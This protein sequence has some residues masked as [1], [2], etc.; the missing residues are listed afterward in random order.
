MKRSQ[1][2][3]AVIDLLSCVIKKEVP[4]EI[5]LHSDFLT[6]QEKVECLLFDGVLSE[7]QSR[8][9]IRRLG[10]HLVSC[11]KVQ[12]A[13]LKKVIEYGFYRPVDRELTT[14][15]QD[16]VAMNAYERTSSDSISSHNLMQS[17]AAI[18]HSMASEKALREMLVYIDED[19]KPES[20]LVHVAEETNKK[21]LKF[22][23]KILKERLC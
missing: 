17:L 5:I 13:W 15:S 14:M 9:L 12:E 11:Y 1:R 2:Q 22:I 3:Q 10:Q 23:K 7:D 8:K 6:T 21:Q 18:H 19:F 4:A 16:A 20:Y